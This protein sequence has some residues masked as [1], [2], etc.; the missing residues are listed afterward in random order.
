[1][2]SY[3]WNAMKLGE[4]K[5]TTPRVCKT[6]EKILPVSMF[7]VNGAGYYEGSCIWCKSQRMK[8]EYKQ[9]KLE[10]G[11]AY[12]AIR[13]KAIKQGAKKRKLSCTIKAGDLKA[14]FE[15]QG[16]LCYY[17]GL[18][19]KIGSVDR[20]DSDCGYVPG[21]IIMCERYLNVFRGDMPRD[22]FI[23][24]CRAVARR[25]CACQDPGTVP[26]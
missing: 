20:I 2:K 16:G 9:K 17:T 13:L 6:C 7:P 5:D 15:A 26:H 11:A 3:Q 19:M 18:P 10:N 4:V 24:L 1:M 23:E 22:E 12:W 14:V 21:N 25:H 8:D